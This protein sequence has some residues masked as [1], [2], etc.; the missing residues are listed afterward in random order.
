MSNRIEEIKKTLK[1]TS[2]TREQ[3]AEELK[4]VVAILDD[5]KAEKNVPELNE[6]KEALEKKI[7]TTNELG[8]KL[9]L[10]KDSLENGWDIS[11]EFDEDEKLKQPKITILKKPNIGDTIYAKDIARECYDL[12]TKE[13]SVEQMMVCLLSIVARFDGEQWN[14]PKIHELG[15]DFLE[16]MIL[17]YRKLL[18]VLL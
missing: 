10:E 13:P 1:R 5:P 3:L 17:R 12:K 2:D 16:H 6:K 11:L 14:A 9:A 8:L 4:G 18:R 7:K 15:V